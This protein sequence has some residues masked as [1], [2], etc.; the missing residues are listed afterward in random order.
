MIDY[1]EAL[2]N[3]GRTHR[4]TPDVL[5]HLRVKC[6]PWARKQ[7]SGYPESHATEEYDETLFVWAEIVFSRFRDNEVCRMRKDILKSIYIDQCSVIRLVEHM[8]GKYRWRIST[9]NAK[10]KG[11]RLVSDAKAYFEAG[12]ETWID[13]MRFEEAE[14]KHRVLRNMISVREA[15]HG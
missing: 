7:I 15:R 4:E 6:Q 5:S 14:Q 8:N 13:L 1:T 11:G 9:A 12:W 10:N 2:E 3:W